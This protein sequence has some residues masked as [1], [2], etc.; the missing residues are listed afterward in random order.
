M[1][2]TCIPL[3]GDFYPKKIKLFRWK[4]SLGSVN[5]ADHLQHRM[6]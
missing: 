4:L 6:P 3:F 1:S 5:F 2:L